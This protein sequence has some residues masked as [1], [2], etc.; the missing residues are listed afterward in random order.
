MSKMYPKLPKGVTLDRDFRKKEARYYFRAR[1]R[2]RSVCGNSREA[3]N[4]SRKLHARGLAYPMFGQ[5]RSWRRS[6]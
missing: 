5:V 3:M 4:L 1:G 6:L 2:K